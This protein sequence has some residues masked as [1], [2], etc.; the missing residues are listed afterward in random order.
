MF[1]WNARFEFSTYLRKQKPFMVRASRVTYVRKASRVIPRRCSNLNRID[2]PAKSLLLSPWRILAEN[3]DSLCTSSRLRL[4]KKANN[5]CNSTDSSVDV[6]DGSFSRISSVLS[7]LCRC[8]S[9]TIFR[10]L[11]P[12]QTRCIFFAAF[13]L[14]LSCCLCCRST[15][16]FCTVFFVPEAFGAHEL[17]AK[18]LVFWPDRL[19]CLVLRLLPLNVWNMVMQNVYPHLPIVLWNY[20][21]SIMPLE[22]S[23]IEV[24]LGTTFRFIMQSRRRDQ[25]KN[26]IEICVKIDQGDSGSNRSGDIQ[27]GLCMLWRMFTR[28]AVRDVHWDSICQSHALWMRLPHS[29]TS[30]VR[31]PEKP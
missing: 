5:S 28:M 31:A 6:C 24:K 7:Q 4:L 1:F 17:A 8:W 2:S 30:F 12:L 15:C 26:E 25:T 22:A 14:S 19:T 3:I 16:A 13:S 11:W 23:R 27:R 20:G 21:G 29:L 18:G 10:T 9:A